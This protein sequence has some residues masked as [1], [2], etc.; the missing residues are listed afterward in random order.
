M[1]SIHNYAIKIA[2][3]DLFSLPIRDDGLGIP[4]LAD[5]ARTELITSRLVNAPLA[6]IIVMQGI[7][8]PD[9]SVAREIAQEE[10]QKRSNAEKL[11]VETI[12]AKLSATTLRAVHQAREK[13]ASNWLSVRPSIEHGFVLNKSE[14]NDAICLRYNQQVKHLPS[15]C[16]CGQPFT[17]THAMNCK[18][19]GYVTIRHNDIRDFEAGLHSKVCSDVETEPALQPVTGERL[20][21]GNAAGDEARLDVR[22][23]GFWRHGQNVFF[24]VRVTKANAASQATQ[25]IRLVLAKHEREKKRQYNQRVMDIEHGTLH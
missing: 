13:G 8:L 18:R 7:E 16:A 5:T 24:D 2:E 23:R 4:I 11:R 9:A 10:R 19:G 15:V 12:D 25:P 17:V 3:I 6:A 20:Q 22:A 1:V 14:F 21:A